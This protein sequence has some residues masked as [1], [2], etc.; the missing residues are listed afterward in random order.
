[1]SYQTVND[2]RKKLLRELAASFR[3]TKQKMIHTPGSMAEAMDWAESA[4]P[5]K[6]HLAVF[7]AMGMA[8]NCTIEAIAK[9]L[10]AG[11]YDL[12]KKDADGG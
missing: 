5:A 11:A 6:Y 2:D 3:A 12:E 1:M 4:I 9:G 8:S 10:E 7:T